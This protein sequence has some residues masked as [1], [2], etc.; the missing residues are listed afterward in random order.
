MEMISLLMA[1]DNE[2]LGIRKVENVE[3]GLSD[4]TVKTVKL[5]NN[6]FWEKV[7]RIYLII[8][9]AKARQ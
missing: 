9:K 1:A 2:A 8:G 3:I 7:Q 6:S 5:K 4:K